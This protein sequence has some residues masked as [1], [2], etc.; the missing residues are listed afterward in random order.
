MTDLEERIAS[1]VYQAMRWAY[2]TGAGFD[3]LPWDAVG[4]TLPKSRAQKAAQD[5]LNDIK[6]EEKTD[7]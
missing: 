2:Q 4:D 6:A 1:H 3:L 7:E 5:I